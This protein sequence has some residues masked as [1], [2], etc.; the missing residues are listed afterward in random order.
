[1][2]HLPLGYSHEMV[3]SDLIPMAA[4]VCGSRS[5]LRASLAEFFSLARADRFI[6][7]WGA[8]GVVE[9]RLSSVGNSRPRRGRVELSP[10]RG[11]SK[12]QLDDRVMT[13]Q[14][15]TGATRC[16]RHQASDAGG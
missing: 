14:P 12:V 16:D 4:V 7:H 6:G 10:R 3:W 1:M 15:D 9:G 13:L 8:E 11:L 5:R 2:P